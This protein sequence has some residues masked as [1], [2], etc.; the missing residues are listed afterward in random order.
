MIQITEHIDRCFADLNTYCEALT[1]K[2]CIGCRF[3]KP[4]DCTDWVRRDNNNKV[5]LIPPEEYNYEIFNT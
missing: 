2:Q 1:V 5:V 3:S 4:V